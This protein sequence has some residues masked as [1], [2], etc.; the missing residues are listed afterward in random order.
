MKILLVKQL[1]NPE[2]TAKSLDFAKELQ[3]RGHEV[4]VLT[5]FP[6]YPLGR[7]YDGYKQQLYKREVMDGVSLIRVPIYPDHSASGFKRFLHYFSYG[8]SA[9]FIGLWLVKKPDVCFVYQGAIPAA[10]PAIILKKLRGIPFLYDINDL[11]PETVATSGMLKN[12]WALK[13]IN[14]WCH[15][16][17]R[18]AAFI[19]VATPGFKK[20]LLAKGVPSEKMEIVSN[21]SRDVISEAVL[22]KTSSDS[23]FK[24]NK[25]N[26]LYAGNLGIVQS[27]T[28]ILTTA[29]ILQEEGN[30]RIQFIFL[31]G[32]ADEERLKQAAIDWNLHNVSFIPRVVSSEVTKYLNAADFLLV[33]LKKDDLFK[34]TIPSKILAYLK[35]GKP[36]LMGLEGDSKAIL[37]EARA[38]YTF[39]PDNPEALK[40]VVQEMSALSKEEIANMGIN[41]KRYYTDN[42]SLISSVDKLEKNF[43]KIKKK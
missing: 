34:I 35:S 2:P 36:I 18:N 3:R 30:T 7:I 25:I 28:T 31:G 26:I 6:S 9:S 27:L 41:G 17:Y 33:H 11:W 24:E 20:N 37:D 38:G 23:Y 12:K 4:E 10:I 39:E 19:T 40:R 8:I 16:N 29:K 14:A 32:G 22:D 15:F 42:L 21:W 43:I 13:L 1:F 5:G